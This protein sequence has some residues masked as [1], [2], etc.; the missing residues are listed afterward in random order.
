MV[1]FVEALKSAMSRSLKP[2]IQS[3][4]FFFSETGLPSLNQSQLQQNVTAGGIPQA[5]Q[6]LGD[7]IDWFILYIL[8]VIIHAYM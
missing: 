2:L 6:P 7:A 4:H 1:R 3:T 8:K 5:A